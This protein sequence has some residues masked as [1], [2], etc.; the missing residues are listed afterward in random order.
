SS[1]TYARAG[2]ENDGKSVDVIDVCAGVDG[3]SRNTLG[4][5][6]VGS[7]PSFGVSK[8]KSSAGKPASSSGVPASPV[9]RT[10]NN[11]SVPTG[12][13]S[14]DGARAP[15][16]VARTSSVVGATV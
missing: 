8:P 10:L 1:S 16:H 14:T 7:A 3:K 11:I 5:F 13:V 2:N 4:D 9:T 6:A 12:A 15:K